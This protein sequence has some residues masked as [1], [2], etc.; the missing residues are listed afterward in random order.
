MISTTLV[1]DI[2]TIPNDEAIK[3]LENPPQP[4][5]FLSWPLHQIVCVS[6]L[7]V[8]EE[9]AAPPTFNLSSF[10]RK[11]L[12]EATI[13]DSV[14]RMLANR[15]DC[16]VTYNGSGFDLPLLR[17][18]SQANGQI[19]P[20]LRRL[21]QL[22]VPRTGAAHLDLLSTMS[23]PG[24]APKAPLADICAALSIPSKATVASSFSSAAANV[25]RKL[26]AIQHR[27]DADVLSTWL[28]KLTLDAD[29]MDDFHVLQDGWKAVASWLALNS[30]RFKHLSAFM[31]VPSVG[32]PAD[33]GAV[34]GCG[35]V[36]PVV[37]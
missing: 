35:P 4:S 13:I 22:Q 37:L 30:A 34:L 12:S 29:C 26:D 9:P 27:C 10:S 5:G 19:T 25:D 23:R 20:A 8:S 28:L 3:S 33:S 31:T 11:T 14:E 1:M 21:S 18:R 16:V 24:G 7:E 17:L 36:N 6:I 2:G 32:F 15:I